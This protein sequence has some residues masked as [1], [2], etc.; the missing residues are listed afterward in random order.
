MLSEE[1]G[2]EKTLAKKAERTVVAGIPTESGVYHLMY[3][4]TPNPR[5][6]LRLIS[7]KSRRSS[8]TIYNMENYEYGPPFPVLYGVYPV[9]YNTCY[10]INTVSVHPYKTL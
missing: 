7:T 8:Q 1:R 5:R 2:K 9:L 10:Y 6:K 3:G 4:F